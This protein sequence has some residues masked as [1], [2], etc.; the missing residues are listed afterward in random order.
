MYLSFFSCLGEAKV[1]LNGSI[2]F[3]SVGRGSDF[4][5]LHALRFGAAYEYVL[6]GGYLASFEMYDR[7]LQANEIMDYMEKSTTYRVGM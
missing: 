2:A 4:F 6:E 1:Y 5:A 3:S 7:V